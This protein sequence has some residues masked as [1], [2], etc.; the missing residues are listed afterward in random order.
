MTVNPR[1]QALML[2]LAAILAIGCDGGG[3][4]SASIDENEND[5]YSNNHNIRRFSHNHPFNYR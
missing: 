3:S 4:S 2:L 1:I 5:N